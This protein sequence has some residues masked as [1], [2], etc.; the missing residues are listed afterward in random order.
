V[1]ETP[2]AAEAPES[3]QRQVVDTALALLEGA[4]A[5]YRQNLDQDF[6]GSHARYGFTLFHSL[7][8]HEKIQN[9]TRLGFE[10]R[11]GVDHYNLGCVAALQENFDLAVTHFEKALEEHPEFADAAQNLALALERGGRS[12]DARRQWRRCLELTLTEP[13]RAAIEAHL[14]ELG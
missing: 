14:A 2:V 11:D 4:V 7:K 8:P 12:E 10:P 13:D 5:K 1:P 3:E 9:L 6:D